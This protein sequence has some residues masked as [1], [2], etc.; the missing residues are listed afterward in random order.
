MKSHLQN[1]VREQ[2]ARGFTLIELMISVSLAT[3]VG[4]LIYTVFIQQTQAYR[5][6]SDLGALQQNLRV[7]ME[8]LSR[9]IAMAGWGLGHDGA[10]WGA[11]GTTAMGTGSVPGSPLYAIHIE[12]DFPLGSG[13]DA[14]EIVMMHPDRS[15]W[16]WTDTSAQGMECT[17]ASIVFDADDAG[18]AALYSGPVVSPGTHNR[19]MCHAPIHQGRPGSYL[20]SVAGPGVAGAVPVSVGNTADFTAEC[21]SNLPTEMLCAPPVHVAYYID[22]VADGTGMGTADL[23]VLYYVPDVTQA[24]GAGGI[25]TYPSGTDIPIALGIED[26]QFEVCQGGAGSTGTDCELAT[27]WTAGYDPTNV[28]A[29][30]WSNLTAVRIHMV[31]RTLRQDYQR[32]AVSTPLD[33]DPNDTQILTNPTADGFH[34]RVATTEV[35]VRNAVG[36]WQVLN[37]GW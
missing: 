27:S 24:S 12:E 26:I 17:T 35:L 22:N 31:A 29:N 16:A 3:L 7:G 18:Q 8:M 28:V 2:L 19:I 10:T 9:D 23:P 14:I 4:V 36:T 11:G 21:E 33:L 13:K 1:K 34:R 5:V 25:G 20:W 37:S 32:T 30:S 15:M 6:Q